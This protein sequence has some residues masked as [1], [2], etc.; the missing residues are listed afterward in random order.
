[1][2]RQAGGVQAGRQAGHTG[3]AAVSDAARNANAA[4]TARNTKKHR[5]QAQTP[6]P[7]LAVC[8]QQL[9]STVRQAY[10]RLATRSTTKGEPLAKPSTRTLARL[11]PSLIR[12]AST[13]RAPKAEPPCTTTHGGIGRQ[14]S[15]GEGKGKK[16]GAT[17]NQRAVE[18]KDASRTV[19][20]P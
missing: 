2:R 14:R 10:L 20:E 11:A 9:S 5:L 12:S 7:T 4:P 15:R 16:V 19:D 3:E 13:G 6:A 8:L 18:G 17:A 1:V